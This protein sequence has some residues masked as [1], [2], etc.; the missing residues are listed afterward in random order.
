M[1]RGEFPS[2][3]VLVGNKMDSE[4]SRKVD[5]SE[6][7]KVSR[8]WGKDVVF[9]EASAKTRVNI[10]EQFFTIARLIREAYSQDTKSQ[11]R[12]KKKGILSTIKQWLVS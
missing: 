5:T 11:K 10:D 7:E 4:E 12:K 8:E 2:P 6:G 3:M 1:L 9:F